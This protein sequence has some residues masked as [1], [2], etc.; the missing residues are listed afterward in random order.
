MTETVERRQEKYKRVREVVSKML[1]DPFEFNTEI[2]NKD[3]DKGTIFHCGEVA[4]SIPWG[5]IYK[6]TIY[7]KFVLEGVDPKDFVGTKSQ[8]GITLN[9]YFFAPGLAIVDNGLT[10]FA[11][12]IKMAR[13]FE[14]VSSS[15]IK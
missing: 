12:D 15:F 9:H 6:Q 1:R 8:H 5:P 2:Y 4:F 10:T 14:K 7:D 3:L 13:A 11:N